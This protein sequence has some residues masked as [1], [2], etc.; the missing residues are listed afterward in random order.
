VEAG[1]L[2]VCRIGCR[3]AGVKDPREMEIYCLRIENECAHLEF[4][5]ASLRGRGCAFLAYGCQD[6]DN[7]RLVLIKGGAKMRSRVGI[8]SQNCSSDWEISPV[9]AK[10]GSIDWMCLYQMVLAGNEGVESLG[11]RKERLAHPQRCSEL[12]FSA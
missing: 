2:G 7:N 11:G 6:I 4:D 8:W 9:V 3:A 5:W 1:S 10:G 12:R